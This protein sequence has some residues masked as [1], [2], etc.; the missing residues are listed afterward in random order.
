M[1]STPT[2]YQEPDF[3]NTDHVYVFTS[4][5]GSTFDSKVERYGGAYFTTNKNYCAYKVTTILCKQR[6]YQ[7]CLDYFDE[8]SKILK[9]L[10]SGSGVHGLPVSAL[11]YLTKERI[12]KLYNVEPE[13]FK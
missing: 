12:I 1:H 5:L 11:S 4:P 10:I 9:W 13:Y 8:K 7:E 6:T 2:E 3:F